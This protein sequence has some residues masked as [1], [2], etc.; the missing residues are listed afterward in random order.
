MPKLFLSY[1]RSDRQQRHHLARRAVALD[2]NQ[3]GYEANSCRISGCSL[4][5]LMSVFAAPARCSRPHS[6]YW[7]PDVSALPV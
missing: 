1:R 5:T 3:D 6:S 2:L 4:A 7:H